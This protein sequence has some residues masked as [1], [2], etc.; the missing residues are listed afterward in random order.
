ML[1]VGKGEPEAASS[2]AHLLRILEP[3]TVWLSA[4][5]LV[6]KRLARA[7]SFRLAVA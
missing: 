2:R 1:P 4:T 3:Y 7:W 5:I 6:Y